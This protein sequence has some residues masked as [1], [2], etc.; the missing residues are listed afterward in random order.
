MYS[1]ILCLRPG[2]AGGLPLCML[3][4]VFRKFQRENSV[5]LPNSMMTTEPMP[6]EVVAAQ[7][8]ASCLRRDMG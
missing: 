3:H 7:I 1:L 6:T 4:D 5:L 8:A 2:S